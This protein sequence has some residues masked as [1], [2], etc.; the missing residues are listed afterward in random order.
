MNG[1]A[2]LSELPVVRAASRPRTACRKRKCDAKTKKEHRSCDD[3]KRKC[4]R[5]ACDSSQE[6]DPRQTP[7]SGLPFALRSRGMRHGY[8]H[9]QIVKRT[10]AKTKQLRG[11][12]SEDGFFMREEIV[13][14]RSDPLPPNMEQTLIIKATMVWAKNLGRPR[15]TGARPPRIDRG[16]KRKQV[17]G[18]V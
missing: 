5:S 8:R 10:F 11:G 4:L 2:A 16:V 3:S 6:L 17:L 14:L 13:Q 9:H 1:P 18:R 7:P 12:Q 15:A